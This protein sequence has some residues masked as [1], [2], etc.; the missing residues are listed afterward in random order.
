MQ[1]TPS[2]HLFYWFIWIL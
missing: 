1:S 2:D